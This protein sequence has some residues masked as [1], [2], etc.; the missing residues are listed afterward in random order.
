MLKYFKK[1]WICGFG[2]WVCFAVFVCAL[3]PLGAWAKDGESFRQKPHILWR[4]RDPAGDRMWHYSPLAYGGKV[5]TGGGDGALYALDAVSGDK[6]WKYQTGR[7]VDASTRGV[8]E[9]YRQNNNFCISKELARDDTHVY[10]GSFDGYN[11]ALD[12]NTGKKVWRA[13]YGKGGC[14]TPPCLAPGTVAY[15]MSFCPV[16]TFDRTNGKVRWTA[17][18]SN[19]DTRLLTSDRKRICVVTYNKIYCL[20]GTTGKILWQKPWKTSPLGHHPAAF[21]GEKIF[22]VDHQGDGTACVALDARNGSEIWRRTSEEYVL[23]VGVGGPLVHDGMVYLVMDGLWALEASTGEV[24]WRAEKSYGKAPFEPLS[25]PAVAGETVIVGA[26]GSVTA[27]DAK[28][29]GRLWDVPTGDM[30]YSTPVA[31]GERIFFGCNDAYLYCLGY[32]DRS[33][34]VPA[35]PWSGPVSVRAD[36]VYSFDGKIY[37]VKRIQNGRELVVL[38]FAS[39]KTV[40]GLPRLPGATV[41]WTDGKW[42]RAVGGKGHCLL[43]DMASG[44]VVSSRPTSGPDIKRARFFSHVGRVAL[45]RVKKKKGARLLVALDMDSGRQLWKADMDSGTRLMEVAGNSGRVFFAKQKKGSGKG[46]SPLI[47]ARDRKTGKL[48]WK[49]SLGL[50]VEPPASAVEY[51]GTLYMGVLSPAW[52]FCPV[53]AVSARTGKIIWKARMEGGDTHVV[54]VDRNALYVQ[55]Q[56]DGRLSALDR[57][58]GKVLWTVRGFSAFIRGSQVHTSSDRPLVMQKDDITIAAVGRTTGKVIAEAIFDRAISGFE[59][60]GDMGCVWSRVPGKSAKQFFLIHLADFPNK[61]TM[62]LAQASTGVD[63]DRIRLLEDRGITRES[64]ERE[65]KALVREKQALA[66]SRRF[67]RTGEEARQTVREA[68]ILRKRIRDYMV[69]RDAFCA[70]YGNLSECPG[71]IDP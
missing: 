42:L 17:P 53:Y 65:Y 27:F 60:M 55:N 33:I 25:R 40:G 63:Q 54:A 18:I 1:T 51:K 49:T 20:D 48:L 24:V 43:V 57:A 45:G 71:K 35:M 58:D 56:M 8:V 14:C 13:R 70:T 34:R 44:S 16:T 9:F 38:D 46:A 26:K 28:I 22:Y 30:V 62:L 6:V 69:K 37:A 66:A 50:P 52:R 19:R 41:T 32:G 21:E 11:Y 47:Q 59:L 61:K 15:S 36:K 4:F 31:W 29:G 3:A 67:I 23:S 10:F 7:E 5:Y 2:M 39:K 68:E 12:L 64:L